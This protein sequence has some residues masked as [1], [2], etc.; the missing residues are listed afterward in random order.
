M[1]PLLLHFTIFNVSLLSCS[2]NVSFCIHWQRG[3]E[4][5]CGLADF[6]GCSDVRQKHVN[7]IAS[8]AMPKTILTCPLIIT[9]PMFSV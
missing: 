6:L 7:C 2:F 5:H 1:I 9:S 4:K 3:A 8:E